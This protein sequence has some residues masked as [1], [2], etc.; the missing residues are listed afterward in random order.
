[1][2]TNKVRAYPEKFVVKSKTRDYQWDVVR[3]S[4]SRDGNSYSFAI[5]GNKHIGNYTSGYMDERMLD[6]GYEFIFPEPALVF[7]FT[8]AGNKE[9]YKVVKDD[10]GAT[11]W[12][13]INSD[14]VSTVPFLYSDEEIKEYIKEGSWIITSVGEQKELSH[15]EGAFNPPAEKASEAP[16]SVVGALKV[17]V[18]SK[19]IKKATEALSAFADA[20]ERVNI[21]L[22]SMQEIMAEMGLTQQ[23]VSVSKWDDFKI[24]FS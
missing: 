4:C 17:E 20:A 9:S 13:D 24:D 6:D 19:G 8:Y 22:E 21:A 23:E 10:R 14:W 7:P 18:T 5:E 3:D 16:A 1:M 15:A 11:W 2:S 12:H